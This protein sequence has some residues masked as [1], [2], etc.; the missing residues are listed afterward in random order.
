VVGVVLQEREKVE[1][2]SATLANEEAGRFEASIGVAEALEDG[3]PAPDAVGLP[4]GG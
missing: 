1:E 3:K 4:G 2:P